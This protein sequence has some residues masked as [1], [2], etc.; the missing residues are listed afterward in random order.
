MRRVVVEGKG[1]WM[2]WGSCLVVVCLV[3]FVLNL[4]LLGVCLEVEGSREEWTEW[5]RTNENGGF[6]QRN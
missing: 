6:N 5:V 2:V 3:F 4:Y 1:K